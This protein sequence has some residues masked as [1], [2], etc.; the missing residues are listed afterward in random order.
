MKTKIIKIGNSRGVR[1]PKSIIEETGLKDEAELDIVN[2]KIVIKPISKNRESWDSAFQRMG[3]NNDDV[4]LDL[5]YSED[6]TVD[7]DINIV[8]NEELKFIEIQGTAEGETF[9]KNKL[10]ELLDVGEK[11]INELIQI[12]KDVLNL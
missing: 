4:L 2:G 8:M 10:V 5:N 9:T 12:Q 7:V 11:G 3:E 6:S 1:I